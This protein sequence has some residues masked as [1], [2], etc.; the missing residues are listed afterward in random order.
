MSGTFDDLTAESIYGA[1][2][3]RGATFELAT[4]QTAFLREEMFSLPGLG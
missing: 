2:A 4:S 1:S 3:S